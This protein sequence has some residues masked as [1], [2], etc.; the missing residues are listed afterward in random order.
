MGEATSVR[1]FYGDG[2][3]AS[4]TPQWHGWRPS[5]SRLVSVTSLDNLFAARWP[6]QRLFFKVDVE[7]AEMEVMSGAEALLAR[8]GKPRWLI[9]VFLQQRDAARSAN[10]QFGGLGHFSRRCSVMATDAR[11]SKLARR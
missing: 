11:R 10:P 9:E 5:F 6:E 2:V 8:S 3:I 1:P 7:G 4:L